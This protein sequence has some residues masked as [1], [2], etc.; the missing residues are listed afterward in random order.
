MPCAELRDSLDNTGGQVPS[1]TRV[2]FTILSS[3]ADIPEEQTEATGKGSGRRPQIAD[4]SLRPGVEFTIFW[5]IFHHS[6]TPLVRGLQSKR[7]K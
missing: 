4:S 1:G 3:L 6:V 2:S 7:L 5:P